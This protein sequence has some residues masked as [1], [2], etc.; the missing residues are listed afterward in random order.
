MIIDRRP[1]GGILSTLAV[2]LAV[3]LIPATPAQAAAADWVRDQQW[4]LAALDIAQAHQL[5]P[6][7][8]EGITIGIM[9]TGVDGTHPDLKGNVLPG[10]DVVGSSDDGWTD[11]QGHGTGMAGLAVAHGHGPGGRDGA[12]GIAPRAKVVPVRIGVGAVENSWVWGDPDYPTDE[13]FAAAVTELASRVQ[14]ISISYSVP[15][16]DRVQEAIKAAAAQGVIFVHSVGNTSDGHWGSAASMN[17]QL[18]VGASG[19]AGQLDP[20]TVEPF[21]FHPIS[22]LAP[23]RS[24]VSTGPD[25]SYREGTGT[26]PSAPIVAAT[27]AL[28]WAEHPELTAD[29]VVW[30]ILATADDVAEPGRDDQ[31]GYGVINPV[32]A[33]LAKE[34]PPS[35]APTGIDPP[36]TGC[37]EEWMVPPAC[38][39]PPPS[40]LAAEPGR[41]ARVPGG[42]IVAAAAGLTLGAF[43]AVVVVLVV[44][45]RR[46]EAA[47]DQS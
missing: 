4:H 20:I 26:S 9:D 25:N 41:S 38:L 11:V 28:I 23:G 22:I 7:L 19:K 44:R 32:A 35:P 39:P 36:P 33:L 40:D 13:Q 43:A 2:L 18:T 16:S 21:P 30:R 12:L 37:P 24:V 6:M 47:G 45:R 46:S 10:L 34:L 29:E 5:A 27:A 14:I 17:M 8:G 31:T 1:V 3:A 15:E 42:P